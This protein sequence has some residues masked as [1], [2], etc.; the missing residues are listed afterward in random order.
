MAYVLA[1]SAALEK[2]N[3]SNLHIIFISI[4]RPLFAKDTKTKITKEPPY[5]KPKLSDEEV[6]KH[7]QKDEKETEINKKQS[8]MIDALPQPPR[9]GIHRGISSETI[10]KITK[11]PET[12]VPSTS[13]VFQRSQSGIALVWTFLVPKAAIFK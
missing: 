11:K 1:Y 9:K 5:K 2:W 3:S 12:S 8:L 4:S 13:K 7:G 10:E 6:R